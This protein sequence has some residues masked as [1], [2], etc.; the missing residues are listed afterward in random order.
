MPRDDGSFRGISVPAEAWTRV[1]G[2]P[3]QRFLAGEVVCEQHPAKPWP[4]EDCEGP[5]MPPLEDHDV[6][7]DSSG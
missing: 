1:F 3:A 4:H 2:T 7:L 6:G 5:G